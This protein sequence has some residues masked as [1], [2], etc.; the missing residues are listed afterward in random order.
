MNMREIINLIEASVASKIDKLG[1]RD[2]SW[3]KNETAYFEYHCNMSHD[4]CDAELW[5]RSHRPVMILKLE[6]KGYGS[7]CMSRCQNGQPR[8]YTVRFEDGFEGFANEDELYVD[9]SFFNK[10]YSPPP[11]DEI[12]QTRSRRSEGRSTTAG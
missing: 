1:H 7:T 6:E 2:N 4:S 5:Y 9:P 8:C 12:A 10:E 3:R 11:E